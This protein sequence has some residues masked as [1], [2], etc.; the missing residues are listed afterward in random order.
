MTLRFILWMKWTKK[1][2]SEICDLFKFDM[3]NYWFRH[4]LDT[5]HS[6]RISKLTFRSVFFFFSFFNCCIA[7]KSD[8]EA[9]R[10]QIFFPSLHRLLF[11]TYS[12]YYSR[13]VAKN[14]YKMETSIIVFGLTVKLFKLCI[15]CIFARILAH[16]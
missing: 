15:R 7:L 13:L 10:I 8:I 14:C 1:K 12:A 5:K 11:L 2:L 9:N 16:W 4:L 6:R 3:I